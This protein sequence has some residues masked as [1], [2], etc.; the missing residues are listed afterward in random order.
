MFHLFLM[1]W[2]Y[3]VAFNDLVSSKDHVLGDTEKRDIVKKVFCGYM[4]C[5]DSV[6]ATA[7][8]S[9]VD[10]L[11]MA[12]T[13]E[14]VVST[15]NSGSDASAGPSMQDIMK[16]ML[17]LHADYPGDRGIV[18]PLLLNVI[19]LKP[20]QSFFMGPNEPHAYLFGDCVECMALS[21][22]VV[23]AGLTPKF[24]HVDILCGM[25]HYK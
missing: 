16:L 21:D 4:T 19:Y 14:E 9:V 11:A 23:R 12:L 1:R 24:K 22:N 13:E 7:I 3:D 25:L 18:A 2:N 15:S 6:A 20:G 8:A 5:D 17:R 10:R